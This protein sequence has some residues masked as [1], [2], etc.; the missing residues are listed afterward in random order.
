MTR[1]AWPAETAAPASGN[2]A[3]FAH[4]GSNLV[5]DLHGDPAQARLAVFSD[6]NHH[7]ALADALAQFARLHPQL[8]EPFYATTPPRVVSEWLAAGALRLGNL[9]LAVRPHAFVSPPGVLERLRAAGSIAAHAPVARNRGA[10]LLVGRGNPLDIRGIADV[11]SGEVRVF[12][13][14]P[15]TEKVSF[16]AYF[17]T[18]RRVASAAGTGLDFVAADGTLAPASRIVL[19]ELIHHREAP[20]AVASGNADCAVVFS[21]LG[22]RYKRIFPEHFDLVALGHEELHVKGDIHV[23]VVG[24]GGEFGAAFA[25]F[26]RGPQAAAIYAHHGM[27]AISTLTRT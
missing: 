22:L 18:L 25:E 2:E 21:H 8:G 20:Q 19:G 24:D 3:A 5:L 13:S 16:D 4:A 17:E 9:R 7:M 14:N 1:L 15:R 26:M 12:L 6:G 10:V 11:A 23:A 27:D